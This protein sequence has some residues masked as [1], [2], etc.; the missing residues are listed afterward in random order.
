MSS[1][2]DIRFCKKGDL[3]VVRIKVG[4]SWLDRSGGWRTIAEATEPAMKLR[5]ELQAEHL[6]DNPTLADQP[7]VDAPGWKLKSLRVRV[8]EVLDKYAK[9]QRLRTTSHIT[10]SLNWAWKTMG[11]EAEKPPKHQCKATFTKLR[12][13]LID[14]DLNER[15]RDLYSKNMRHFFGMV[16]DLNQDFLVELGNLPRSST[17]AKGSGDAFQRSDFSVIF[18][19]LDTASE[20]EQGLIWIGLSGGPQIVDAVFL[21]LA[22]VNWETGRIRY[23]RIKTGEA[24]EYYALPPLLDWLKR[25]KAALASD[26]VYFFPELIFLDT[27]LK[28]PL[29]NTATWK[30]FTQ[31]KDGR[32][33]QSY[34]ARGGIYGVN[35]M[36]KF[37]T[38]C[39]LKTKEITYKSFRK[40]NISFWTSVGIKVTTRMLMAGHSQLEAHQRYDVPAEFELV[41][42]RDILWNYYQSIMTKQPFNIPT[43]AYDI[44]EAMKLNYAGLQGKL[45]QALAENAGLRQQLQLVDAKLDRLL[46]LQIAGGKSEPDLAE[47]LLLPQV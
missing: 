35:R 33:P 26:A 4:K 20:V 32:V 36:T 17:P 21:P 7:A 27:D 30:G 14:G 25:R 38:R 8:A 29:C 3:V 15:T 42:S 6:R 19:Q 23:T 5:D 43:S 10:T 22:A 37:L 41:R 18:E 24:I 47:G 1:L 12:D 40:H 34:A 46:S 28:D 44:Y 45:E 39:G 11:A 16:T 31:W 2:K 13:K 9:R